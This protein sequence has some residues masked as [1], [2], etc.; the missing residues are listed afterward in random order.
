M[1]SLTEV[2]TGDLAYGWGRK[3]RPESYRSGRTARGG[4]T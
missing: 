4:M 1:K 2:T 3:T